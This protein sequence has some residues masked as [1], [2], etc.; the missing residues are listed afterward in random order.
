MALLTVP[1]AKLADQLLLRGIGQDDFAVMVEA[2]QHGRLAV[3]R[4]MMVA[5]SSGRS[6]FLW[7]ITGP[8]APECGVGLNGEAESLDQAKGDFRAAF[9]RLL[10]WA[11]MSRDG[12]LRWHTEARRVAG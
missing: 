5:R 8:A 10:H 2:G 6:P 4:I 11:A 12:E 3:G 7:T 9:D 1:V